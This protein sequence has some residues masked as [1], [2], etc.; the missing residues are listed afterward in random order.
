MRPNKTTEAPN[1][2]NS[3]KGPR[4]SSSTNRPIVEEVEAEVIAENL[5]DDE[6]RQS[7]QENESDL[8]LEDTI[9]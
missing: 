9:N 1:S 2:T 6:E 3:L 5:A 4:N 7:S 8:S